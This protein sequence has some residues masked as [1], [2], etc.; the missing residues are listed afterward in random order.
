[1]KRDGLES[2]P[3]LFLG[4]GN[5]ERDTKSLNHRGHRGGLIHFLGLKSSAAE[6]MQ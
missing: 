2:V 3:L 4:A 6:F 5:C 1:M